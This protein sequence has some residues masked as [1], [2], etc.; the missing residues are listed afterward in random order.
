MT[1]EVMA[2]VHL[3]MEMVAEVM[4]KEVVATDREKSW[5][6]VEMECPSVGKVASKLG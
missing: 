6:T 1:A 2:V 4:A 3:A 5:G